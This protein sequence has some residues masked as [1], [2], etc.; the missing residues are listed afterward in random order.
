MRYKYPQEYGPKMTEHDDRMT[1]DE[2]LEDWLF[3]IELGLEDDSMEELFCMTHHSYSAEHNLDAIAYAADYFGI[4]LSD[5][6][7]PIRLEDN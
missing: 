6:P 5:D 3:S 2:A 1:P 4:D 7:L